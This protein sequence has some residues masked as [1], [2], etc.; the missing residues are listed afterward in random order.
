MSKKGTH[1]GVRR[2]DDHAD[3]KAY[4]GLHEAAVHAARKAHLKGNRADG[5][6]NRRSRPSILTALAQW[7]VSAGRLDSPEGKSSGKQLL[8]EEIAALSEKKRGAVYAYYVEKVRLLLIL[9]ALLPVIILVLLNFIRIGP[10]PVPEQGLRRADYGEQAREEDLLAD[11]E[12]ETL[13]VQVQVN[14]RKYTIEQADQLLEQARTELEEVLPGMNA[15]LDEVRSQLNLPSHLAGGKVTAEYTLVPYGMIGQDGTIMKEVPQ[16]GEMI[17]IS[18]LLTCGERKLTFQTAVKVLPPLYSREE[19]LRRSLIGDT[20]EAEADQAESQYFILPDRTDGKHVTWSYPGEDTWQLALLLLAALFPAV[21][22]GKDLDI[23]KQAAARK[24]QMEMDYPELL[25]K[26]TVLL[27]AGMTIRAV[28]FRLAHAYE[29]HERT[30][31]KRY[32]YEE[33]CYTCREMQSGVPEAAAYERFGRRSG[34]QTYN[35]LGGLLA[36]NMKKGPKGLAAMLEKEA[37]LT[38]DAQKSM[39]RKRA[40]RAQTKLLFPMILMLG[41]VM[42]ILILPAFMSMGVS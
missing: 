15:S 19:Q 29:E 21:Y 37:Q 20:K 8:H 36:M 23:H 5:S 35:R 9:L 25:W 38:L 12:G 22:F 40:E 33:I 27:G 34:L 28:F 4:P 41:V 17:E 42:M 2:A 31:R 32:A 7:L 13:Q 26:M 1:P 39:A 18:A 3:G 10:A 14:P 6:G 30:S 24:E 11:V 16:D